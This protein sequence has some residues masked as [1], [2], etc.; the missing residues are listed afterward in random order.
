MSN[1]CD[2][3]GAWAR[4]NEWIPFSLTPRFSEVSERAWFLTV[5]VSAVSRL[6][7][8]VETAQHC[9][10]STDTPL[11]RGVNESRDVSKLLAATGRYVINRCP[12][13]KAAVKSSS[14]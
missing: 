6:T 14:P 11:K 9:V 12:I 3:S 10:P 4:T 8:I 2:E 13:R 7:V 5:T 1:G